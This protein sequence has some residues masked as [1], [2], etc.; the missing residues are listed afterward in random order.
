MRVLKASV[1]FVRF[2]GGGLPLRREGMRGQEPS[3]D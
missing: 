2:Q 3:F 1:I